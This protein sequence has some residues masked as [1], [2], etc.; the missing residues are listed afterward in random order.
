MLV[1]YVAYPL[2]NTPSQLTLELRWRRRRTY[3][4]RRTSFHSAMKPPQPTAPPSSFSPFEFIERLDL[5]F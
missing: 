2:P 4:L 5:D 1:T 3:D